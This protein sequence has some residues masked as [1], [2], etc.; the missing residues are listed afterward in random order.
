VS[1][2]R[3]TILGA[4]AAAVLGAAGAAGPAEG[5]STSARTV[6]VYALVSKEQFVNNRDDR[7]RGLGTNPF[8][9]SAGTGR[10]GTNEKAKGPLAGDEGYFQFTLY[11]DSSLRTKVGTGILSCGYGFER[12]GTCDASYSL[13]G[14]SYVGFGVFPATTTAPIT[15]NVTGGTGGNSGLRGTLRISR[16]TSQNAAGNTQITHN[17]PALL[18]EPQ[19]LDFSLV[20]AKASPSAKLTL[21]SRATQE[22]F[23]DND[24]DE[25]LGYTVNPFGMRDP[26]VENSRKGEGPFPGDES[27]FRFAVSKTAAKTSSPAVT[28]TYT[29]EYAFARNAFCNASYR[30]AGGTIFAGGTFSFDA[31]SYTLAVTGGTGVYAGASGELTSSPGADGAQKLSISLGGAGAS[32]APKTSFTLYTQATAEQYVNNADDR[33]RGKGNNPFGNFHDTGATTK[34]KKGPFPGDAALLTFG[35]FRT[36]TK[37]GNVGTASFDC[38]YNFEKD[39]YCGVRYRLGAGTLV[40]SS[41]FNFG[42]N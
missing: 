31:K 40:G 2:R 33:L 8:G 4:I 1:F 18:L 12:S 9:N 27:L 42:T 5:D 32:A 37:T 34:Q 41:A 21:Y 7:Q 38:N 29:C 3:V 20:P 16:D 35:V 11:R 25:E 24:D 10:A 30:F 26:A 17:V 19:R 6:T 23:I 15:L 22:Q 14:G 13:G 28:G 36:A 39:A